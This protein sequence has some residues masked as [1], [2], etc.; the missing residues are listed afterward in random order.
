MATAKQAR[1]TSDVKG[2]LIL[3]DDDFGNVLAIEGNGAKNESQKL[4]VVTWAMSQELAARG[5]TSEVLK[6]PSRER[7]SGW[8]KL[9]SFK[10]GSD[11]FDGT[12]LITD[13]GSSVSK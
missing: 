12:L 6:Q 2:K 11:H 8:L 9:S 13:F 1:F 5:L 3:F 10:C 7:M 4:L